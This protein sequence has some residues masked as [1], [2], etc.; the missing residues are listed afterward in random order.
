MS[1]EEMMMDE[2][3]ELLTLEDEEGKEQMFELL[4]SMEYKGTTYF[5]LIPYHEDAAEAL[6]DDGSVVLLKQVT[7]DGEEMLATLDDDEEFDTVG[8]MFMEELEDYYEYDEDDE[9]Q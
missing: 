2:S 4:D 7:V 9:E 3:P 5:A 1:D 8:Q 6:E